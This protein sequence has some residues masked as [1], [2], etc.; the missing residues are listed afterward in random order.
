MTEEPVR[1]DEPKV[2]HA[3]EEAPTETD[4]ENENEVLRADLR[5]RDEHEPQED[6]PDRR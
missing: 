6:D 1:K 5:Q 4:L 3:S 2:W